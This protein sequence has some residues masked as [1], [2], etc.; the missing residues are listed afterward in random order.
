MAGC[1]PSKPIEFN[2]I[3][4]RIERLERNAREA[5]IGEI[6]PDIASKPAY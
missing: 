2:P 5:R 1:E 4:A 3:E 6:F